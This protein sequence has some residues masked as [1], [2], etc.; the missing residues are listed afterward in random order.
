M[1]NFSDLIGT[2]FKTG[3][4]GPDYFDCYGLV[5][6]MAKRD[7][8]ELPDFGTHSN[9]GVISA[10]VGASLPQWEEVSQKAGAVV[11]IRIGRYVSHVGY[12]IN[13]D[14]MIHSWDQAN[15]VSTLKVDTWKNRIVGFYKHVGN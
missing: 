1:A 13:D 3:G 10:L 12:M 2:P 8:I 14:E 5:M 15:G 11:L 9:Q 7:G 6:E 4:R